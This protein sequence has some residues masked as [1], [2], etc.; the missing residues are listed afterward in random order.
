M[1]TAQ[2]SNADLQQL[3]KNQQSVSTDTEKW[4]AVVERDESKDGLFVFGV[5]STRIYCR[6]SCPARHPNPDQVVFFSQPDEAERSGFRA[7]KRCHPR[8]TRTSARAELIQRT[9]AYIEANLDEKLTLE[10]LSR[11]AG[12]SPFHF[13]RTFKKF[14]GISP[15]QYVEAGR[16]ERVKRS[17]TSGETVTNSLYSAGFTSKSRLYEKTLPQLG[18]N[19]GLFRRGGQGLSIRYTIIDSRIGRVLLAATERG[20]CAV[21][22]GG[23]DEAVEAAL[24]ED[25]YAAEL[26]RDDNGMEQWAEALQSYFDGHEFPRDLPLDLQATAFQWRVWKEIQ[27]IPYGHTV[28]YSN[29]AKS[30]GT[31][32]AARAV[33]RACATNPVAI[34]IPC[35]RVIGKDGSLRGYGWGMRRKKTLLSLE[36]KAQSD[37]TS[38]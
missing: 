16:L 8:E 11:Q 3:Q 26:H 10:N 12:L 30:L 37:L 17:L 23:S 19:P 33:A 34:V 35:H 14:L 2:R 32:R 18:V 9:C 29:L 27:S 24:R 21:C 20:A 15:R 28:S 25:Y 4:K 13:Q 1:L 31:P 38:A 5:R 7:C 36:N 22:M 6:P